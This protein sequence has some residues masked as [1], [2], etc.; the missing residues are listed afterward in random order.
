LKKRFDLYLH[1]VNLKEKRETENFKIKGFGLTSTMKRKQAITDKSEN[2]DVF[3]ENEHSAPS[4]AHFRH[5]KV[6]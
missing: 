5:R 4:C 3:D 1:C 2:R 6:D